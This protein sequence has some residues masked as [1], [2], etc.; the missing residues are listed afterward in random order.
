MPAPKD[1]LRGTTQGRID[2]AFQARL[3]A[4]KARALANAQ[5]SSGSGTR[6]WDLPPELV[7]DLLDI[8]NLH[9]PAH[10]RTNLNTNYSTVT[11]AAGKA[12][13]TGDMIA[14]LH[15]IDFMAAEERAL[16]LR[17]SSVKIGRAH[18]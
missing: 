6:L 12:G 4:L 5:A 15:Q 17:H 3:N 8:A 10:D 14:L 13:T 7:T 11:A 18:V 2:P 1:S 16:R 9:V